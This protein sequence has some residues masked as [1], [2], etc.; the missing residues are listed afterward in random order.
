MMQEKKQSCGPA[1]V[2]MTKVYYTSSISEGLEAETRR[3]SQNYPG[4]F[5]ETG[6]TLITNLV[7]VL[8]QEGVKTYKALQVG[9]VWNYIYGYT[10][11][12][13]P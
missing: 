11:E 8:Q 3:I 7:S 9:N 10:K 13:T 6:G 4:K 5:T 12:E 1:C 2:A